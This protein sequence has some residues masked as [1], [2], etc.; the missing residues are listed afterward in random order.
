MRIIPL[1][2]LGCLALHLP[3]VGQVLE[4]RGACDG[5]GA[6]VLP[7]GSIA[8]VDDEKA[9]V[10]RIFDAAGGKP[11]ALV[12]IP[13]V[14]DSDIEPDLEGGARVGSMSLWIGSHGRNSAGKPRPERQ[15]LFGIRITGII[16]RSIPQSD[17]LRVGSLR[18]ALVAWGSQHSIDLAGAFGAQEQQ[19]DDLAAEKQ[20]VNIEAIA[21]D[22]RTRDLLIGF[23][24]PVPG[25]QALIAPL[26]NLE[27]VLRG[28]TAEFGS[29]IQ[30]RLGGSGLRDMVWSDRHAAFLLIAGPS[31]DN[32]AFTL[33]RWNGASLTPIPWA[34]E[35]PAGFHPETVLALPG[36]DDVLVLSDDGDVTASRDQAD[37]KNGD[38]HA[39]SGTCSCKNI[40]NSRAAALRFFRGLRMTVQGN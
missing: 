38:F 8:T 22:P 36:S 2:L 39:T 19:V 4:F 21:Y 28:E 34:N 30:L 6:I 5:S 3:A 11:T 9:P 31:G 40:R 24:N 27:A 17:V 16:A 23:R 20:G 7:D 13:G 26:R 33:Y 10:L 29:P 37:C 12:R 18:N 1:A 14:S 15:V 35:L 32:G 25:G